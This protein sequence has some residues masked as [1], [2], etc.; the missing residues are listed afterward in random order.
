MST[1]RVVQAT[2]GGNCTL[3]GVAINHPLTCSTQHTSVGCA[4]GA[5]FVLL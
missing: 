5:M 3:V 1:M 4:S 2:N